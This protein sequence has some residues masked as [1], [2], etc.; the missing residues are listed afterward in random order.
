[1]EELQIF[2]FEKNDVRTITI[3]EEP[4][5][6]GKDVAEV[7]G[8]SRPDNAIRT[9]VDAEDK[10]MHRIGASGQSRNMSVINESGLYSLIFSSHL[11]SAKRFKRW[12]T[13]EVLPKIRQTGKYEAPKDPMEIMRLQFE[14]LDQ[15]NKKVAT[16]EKDVTYLKDEVKLEAGEY[17]YI[18]RHVSKTVMETIRAFAYA[19]TKDVKAALFKDINR[20]INEVAGVKTRTQ[21]RQKHFNLVIDFINEWVPSTATRLKVQ[22]LSLEFADDQVDGQANV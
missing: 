10:L 18:N 11:D 19:N 14:A 4:Y 15:T 3:N 7:L 22:Q 12:V 8:Y 2:S 13:S 5:F 17:G 21:L 16:I 6:I 9:H 20:G 1:M